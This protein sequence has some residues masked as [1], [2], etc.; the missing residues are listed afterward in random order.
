[1]SRSGDVHGAGPLGFV[2]RA[3]WRT[4]RR[5]GAL[6]SCS[7]AWNC[8]AGIPFILWTGTP[9]VCSSMFQP[10]LFIFKHAQLQPAVSAGT[11]SLA[12]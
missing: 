3:L 7:Q 10:V 9:G 11:V 1:M 4:N 6:L 5:L 2:P 8:A 12:A